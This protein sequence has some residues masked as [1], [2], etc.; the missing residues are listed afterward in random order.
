MKIH[1]VI[2]GQTLEAADL[3][4]GLVPAHD[5]QVVKRVRAMLVEKLEGL[6]CSTHGQ[7]AT[8]IVAGP[9]SQQLGLELKT[10]CDDFL[11][12]ASARLEPPGQHH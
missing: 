2:A 9:S 8:A 3:D 10:C 12:V 6:E 7:E 5:V 11:T 4:S 1:V